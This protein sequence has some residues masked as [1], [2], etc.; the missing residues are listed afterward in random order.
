M[1][2]TIPITPKLKSFFKY[3]VVPSPPHEGAAI[4]FRKIELP[5]YRD[6]FFV[7]LCIKSKHRPV[8]IISILLLLTETLITSKNL[9]LSPK[10]AFADYI[11]SD[12]EVLIF[13]FG[14]THDFFKGASHAK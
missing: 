4:P 14:N 8:S 3:M 13:N 9:P 5:D 7:S 11:E 2:L 6:D 12:K 1:T 10:F